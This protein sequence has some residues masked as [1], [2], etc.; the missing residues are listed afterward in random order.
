MAKPK[1]L[2]SGSYRIQ[3]FLGKDPDGK[4]IRKS[5]T[6]ATA[7]ECKVLAAQYE[8][9]HRRPDR[10][11]FSSA[12]EAY[13]ASSAAVLSPSTLRGYKSVQRKLEPLDLSR[14]HVDDITQA[15]V[16]EAIDTLAMQKTDKTPPALR[17]KGVKRTGGR[18][19]PKTI[20]N[21][22]GFISAV[23]AS[24]GI[25]IKGVKLPQKVRSELEVPE[26]EIIKKLFQELK[27][28]ALEV[29]VM[30]AA[31]G[32][33][34]RGEICAL[35]IDDLNGNI[36]HVCKSMVKDPDGHWVV[37]PPKTY[38]SD[39]Y[40]ELPPYVADLIRSQGYVVRATPSTL[41][42]NHARFLKRHGFPSYHLHGYRHYM[43]SALHAAGVPDSY[44][45]Q[46][47]GWSTDHTMKAVYRHTLADRSA[48]AVRKA[49]AHF[50][51]LL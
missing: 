47:G 39:R 33:L 40:V 30:L 15:D 10:R 31:I 21:I 14:M 12:M 32:G 50:E 13:I 1:K 27:G 17:E 2:P 49:N 43:V 34:R 28:T 20:R 44:I 42:D 11:T 48:E 46:R 6:A 51:S 8:A 18:T 16:Q 22:N 29:P 26:D 7:K 25:Y 45:Q 37:K 4:S 38:S 24:C 35:T 36:L 23:L 41:S 19:S 9:E 3:I 5:I